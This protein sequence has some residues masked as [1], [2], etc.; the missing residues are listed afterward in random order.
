MI[1][2]EQLQCVSANQD[3]PSHGTKEAIT[4]QIFW[5]FRIFKFMNWKYKMESFSMDHVSS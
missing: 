2:I 4:S 3:K 5:A 1:P